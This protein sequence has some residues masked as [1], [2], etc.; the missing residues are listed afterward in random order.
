MIGAVGNQSRDRCKHIDRTRPGRDRLHRGGAGVGSREAVIEV[1]ARHATVGKH[2]PS[3]CGRRCAYRG[4]GSRHGHR[5]V[6]GGGESSICSVSRAAE[7]CGGIHSDKAEM[8]SR[9]RG[10]SRDG[11]AQAHGRSAVA[12][13]L[14]RSHAAIAHRESVFKVRGRCE[15][16]GIGG[17][18]QR[19]SGLADIARRARLC[20]RRLIAAKI[21]CER[22]NILA[23]VVGV[24]CHH[25]PAVGL[26]GDTL[27]NSIA[28]SNVGGHAAGAVK[29][30][31][32][33]EI[34]I[35]AHQRKV[36]RA[37]VA[38]EGRPHSNDSSVSLHDP[39]VASVAPETDSG[40]SARII[41]SIRAVTH[42][43]EVGIAGVAKHDDSAICLQSRTI[44]TAT[45]QLPLAGA[46]EAGVQASIGVIAAHLKAASVIV[47]AGDDLA[48]ALQH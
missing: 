40:G 37:G 46:I 1:N 10:K 24:A 16:V 42:D 4:G 5:R 23:A 19:S 34:G 11:R 39:A 22:E 12:T 7:E 21:P 28:A 15:T 18:S 29:A 3:Q 26:Q 20:D 6:S 41:N 2:H 14:I 8:V 48:I 17:A 33:A 13:G 32:E 44:T 25:D 45:H 27:T 38:V 30:S 9:V 35:V 47:A 31:V 36:M 43:L